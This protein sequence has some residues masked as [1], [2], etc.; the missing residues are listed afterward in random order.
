MGQ[1]QTV[2]LL[3]ILWHGQQSLGKSGRLRFLELAELLV[4]IRSQH[5]YDGFTSASHPLRCAGQRRVHNSAEAV[6]G[7]L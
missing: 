7:I 4:F 2:E 1:W 3:V 5:Y 6:L